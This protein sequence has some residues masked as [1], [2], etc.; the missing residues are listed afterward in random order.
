MP[1]N[2]TKSD[3]TFYHKKLKCLDIPTVQLQGDY[4]SVRAQSLVLN[5][6]KCQ[7]STS[8][9]ICKSPEDIDM[10]LRRKFVLVNSNRMRFSTRDYKSRSKIAKE[11]H[12]SWIPINSQLREEVV[13]K[14]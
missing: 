9:T 7:N 1:H 14:I 3:L 8:G 2:I 12:L 13:Y 10:W 4:N 5:F 6:E 11:S